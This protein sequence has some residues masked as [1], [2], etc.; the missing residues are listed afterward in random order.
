MDLHEE[1]LV[2]G[3]VE[4]ISNN[5]VFVK[6]PDGSEGTIISSE[7]APGRIKNMRQYVVPNKKIVCKVLRVSGKHINLSL[8]RVNSKE[9]KEVM[10]KFKQE[11]TSKSAVHSILK[12]KANKVEEKILKDFNSLF[13][14]FVEAREDEKLINKYF[15]KEFHEAIKKITEKKKKQVDLSKI[16]RLKCLESDGIKKIRKIFPDDKSVKITYISAGEFKLKLTANNYK[17]GNKKMQEV[18]AIV[19]ESAKSNKCDFSSEEIKR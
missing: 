12:D 11:Q 1:D 8:R 7:I 16:V 19:E 13:D 3:K 4:K 18:L 17:E 10:Q 9:K 5:I 14:F 2:L 15:P 6:L